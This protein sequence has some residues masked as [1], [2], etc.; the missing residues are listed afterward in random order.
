MACITDFPAK[1]MTWGYMGG[2]VQPPTTKYD[3]LEGR[4]QRVPPG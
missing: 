2:Q 3:F 4:A 1:D